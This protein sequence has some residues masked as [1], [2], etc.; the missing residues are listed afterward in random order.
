MGRLMSFSGRNI[1]LLCKNHHFL[2]DT[3]RLNDQEW[4]IVFDKLLKVGKEI[5]DLID[6]D[7]IPKGKVNGAVHKRKLAMIKNWREQYIAVIK[8]YGKANP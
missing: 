6:G 8:N 4:R 7:L 3:F 5:D 2:F 1:I